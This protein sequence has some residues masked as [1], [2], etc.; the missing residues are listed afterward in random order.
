MT[1]PRRRGVHPG[2]PRGS[3]S[4]IGRAIARRHGGSESGFTLLELIIVTVIVPLV[5][6]GLAI[7]LFSVFTLQGSVSNRL[8]DSGDSQVVGANFQT[9]VQT[10]VGITTDPSL[11]GVQCG[12]STQNLVGFRWGLVGTVYQDYVD[13]ADVPNGSSHNL[14]RYSCTA[15]PSS[16]PNSTTI[17]S[18]NVEAPCPSFAVTTNCQGSPTILPAADANNAQGGY[19]DTKSVQ[20]VEFQLYEP[21]STENGPC[22]PPSSGS[23]SKCYAYSLS[24]VPAY[25]AAVEAD[26]GQPISNASTTGCNFATPGTGTYAETMCLVDFSSLI[27]NNLL[28]AE[29]GCLEMSVSLP[30]GATLYFCIGITGTSVYPSALPTWQNGF[31]GNSCAGSTS[32]CTN[33]TPFYTGI[34]GQPA[35]Y[36]TGSGTTTINFT[37][38]SVVNQQG[39]LATGWEVVSADAESTDQGESIQ[40]TT[41]STTENVEGVVKPEYPLTIM[42]NDEPYD[43]TSDPTGNACSTANNPANYAMGLTQPYPW[44]V[45]CAVPS[46]VAIGLK[47]GTAMVWAPAPPSLSVQM[48]GGGLEAIVFGLLV[49]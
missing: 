38:I 10:A 13:Y 17:I 39:L 46:S 14:V 41:P 37:N 2:S 32:G 44:Q 11:P 19:Q 36:Q 34:A 24:G 28:A 18:Y 45:I 8:G 33:G 26:G 42:N 40:W 48:V 43:T 47:T 35:L 9:D 16:T 30:G 15:G 20:K 1:K 25:Y 4:P 3:A 7:G 22:G 27:G 12:S 49:S 6:G 31:L 23:T 21:N 29:Q 5:V